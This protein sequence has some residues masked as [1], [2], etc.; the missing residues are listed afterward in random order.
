MD[1]P[2][3]L[4]AL[5]TLTLSDDKRDVD[6]VSRLMV[7]F[8]RSGCDIYL[9]VN[10]Q[11]TISSL[12]HRSTKPETPT[13]SCTKPPTGLMALAQ[14]RPCPIHQVAAGS[15]LPETVMAISL[16]VTMVCLVMTAT[17]MM[18]T[19][20]E[21]RVQDHPPPQRV[22]LARSASATRGG[23]ISVTIHLV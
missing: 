23:S 13:S 19:D 2:A 5:S 18:A 21:A 15:F 10:A 8:S 1:L 16:T 9:K 3:S 20:R 22:L 14:P 12:A 17:A 6:N 4:E 11:L 7:R